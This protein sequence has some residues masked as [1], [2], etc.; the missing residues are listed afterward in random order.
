[1]KVG[2][3]GLGRM[4]RGIAENLVKRGVSLRVFDA[5]PQAVA[6][7][8]ERGAV[9]APSVAEVAREVDVMFTSLPGP[10]QV[11]EVVLGADGIL[12]NMKPGLV[13][14]DL[15]TSSAALNRRIYDAFKA[16]GG[17]M[18]DAPVSGQPAGAAAGTL[19]VWVGGDEEVYER[20][21][22]L[23]RKF[24]NKP[25]H[26]GEIGSGTVV[27]LLHSMSAFT[28]L[29]T[30]SEVFSVGT[31]AGVEPLRLWEALRMGVIGQQGALGMLTNHFLPGKYDPPGF[32]QKLAHK[33]MRL[34]T[35]L[36]KDVGVPVRLA[37]MTM[38]EM[39]EALARGWGD[40]DSRSYLKIQLERAGVQMAVAPQRIKEAL[41]RQI[42]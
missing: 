38:E 3:I 28:I 4:G 16:K 21:L 37:N 19:A 41:Q 2:F 13:L 10:P 26:V 31:K 7:L 40:G 5:N 34:A 9:A 15:S 11:E 33:D 32:L 17:S 25:L 12:A 35:Q 24:A 29:L 8:V 36:A 39:T 22:D 1:M 6:A 42:P 20:H 18:L 27:K 14:F 23:I 30:M